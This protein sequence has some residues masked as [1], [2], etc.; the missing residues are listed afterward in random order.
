MKEL[1]AILAIALIVTTAV[2]VASS[3]QAPIEIE[4]ASWYSLNS[5][6]QVS[7]G[8]SYVP[9]F[10]T[11]VAI[12]QMLDLNVSLN[13]TSLNG[14][15][16]YSYVHGP[17]KE[18]RDYFDFPEV[19]EG[20]KYSIYQL[21]N[22]SSGISDGMYQV[23]VDYSF[24]VGNVT[25]K[26]NENV[27]V[28]ILGN[29]KLAASN[30]FFGTPD[31]PIEATS[32]MNNLPF[33]VYI[34]NYGNSPVANVSVTYSPQYPMSGSYQRDI[35]PAIPSYSYEP[36]TF[37]VNTGPSGTVI[38]QYLNVSFYGISM[39]LPF[40]LRLSGFPYLVPAGSQLGSS[41]LI[42]SEG[43]KNV[44]ISFYVE[45]D[46]PIPA[47][48]VSVHFSPSYPLAGTNQSTIISVIPAYSPVEVTFIVNVT[49]GAS[50]FPENIT[51]YY[52]GS[53]HSLSYKVILP[54]Y[55]NVSLVSYFSNPPVIYQGEE[56]VQLQVVLINGGNSF[57]PPLNISLNSTSFNIL[58]GGYSFPSIPAGRMINLTFLIN[59]GNNTGNQTLYLHVNGKTYTLR[60]RILN[61]GSVSITAPNISVVSGSSSNL[62]SFMVKNTGKVTLVDLQFHILTPDVFSIHIPSSN[63]LGGLTANNITFSQLSPGSSIVVTFVIDVSS[64]A[65][66]GSYPSQLSLVY[67]TNNSTIEFF[68]TFTFN[69]SVE[70]TAFQKLSSLTGLTYLV[71]GV[72]VILIAVFSVLILRRRKKN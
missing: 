48:N 23:P 4:G 57:S 24:V 63:P 35:L 37:F 62:F 40:T 66:P 56:Y 46:S 10:V 9:L 15:L 41:S 6:S 59:A 14:A 19:S 2:P 31:S 52:N 69:V 53:L 60:E 43:M 3:S 71:I 11:F 68:K 45:D 13:Y 33:T 18:V 7:P 26:G 49:G 64:A 44:P 47:E 54:G 38:D 25:V 55:G 39:E 65:Q 21:T 67:R 1:V 28:P 12:S 30:S 34:E 36:V 5:T 51:L 70:Q 8:Y 72:A 42:V 29:V 50:S 32:F 61:K 22:V 20:S 17:N 58:T 27:T 16:E